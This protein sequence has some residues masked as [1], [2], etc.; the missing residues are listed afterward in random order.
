MSSSSP[1][2]NKDRMTA[3]VTIG[4]PFLDPGPFFKDAI[5]SV[6]AQ[7]FRDWELILVDD[8]S[9]DGSLEAARA[10]KSDRVKVISDGQRKG[11]PRRLN[12]IAEMSEGRYLA[13]MDADDIMHPRRIESQVDSLEAQGAD[14]LTTGAWMIDEKNR[15]TGQSY[16]HRTFTPGERPISILKW[17]PGIHP[18]LAGR[19]EWFRENPYDPGYPRAED[20]ELFIRVLGRSF[21]G[22]LEENLYFYR[23]PDRFGV[24]AYLQSYASER[25]VLRRYGL[26]LA[27]QAHTLTLI[28]RS[29]VK[30]AVLWISARLGIHNRILRKKYPAAS[31]EERARAESVIGEVVKT[32]VPGWDA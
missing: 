18:T 28:Q 15:V 25:K 19:R 10:I 14:A 5:R 2:S 31:E 22:G 21:I 32:R 3:P 24:G 7:T 6:F 30:S 16:K 4:I 9:S 20:R 26:E 23:R 17:G 27:G 12:Q 1:S 29:L 8:G 11:L 13:R